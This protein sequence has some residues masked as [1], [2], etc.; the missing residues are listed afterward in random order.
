MWRWLKL[1]QVQDELSIRVCIFS[2]VILSSHVPSQL[3]SLI[4]LL[5]CLNTPVTESGTTCA[6]PQS[7]SL[8]G[9]V[10]EQSPITGYEPK[11]LIEISSEYTPT[12][13]PSRN[14]SFTT[15]TD[16]VPNVVVSDITETIEAGQLISPL[17][18]QERE[19][20][21]TSFGV[22]FFQQ[23]AAGGS[24]QQPAPSLW[25]TSNAGSCGKLQRSDES[26]SNVE[27]SLMRGKRDRDF[28]S[29][30]SSQ[31]D[32]ERILS[33]RK[34]LHEYLEKEAERG[35]QG[36]CTAQRRFPEAEVEMDR[37]SWE[38]RNSDIAPNETNQQLE[39]QRLELYQANERGWSSSR[40][41]RDK[42]NYE[43]FV[44]TVENWW[45]VDAEIRETIYRESA[46]VLYS[47]TTEQ[48]EFLEWRKRVLWSWDS[49]QLWNVHVPSEPHEIRVPE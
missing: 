21:A 34:K 29:V 23:A 38:R 17:F 10:A 37:K 32:W 3:A 18:T 19:V 25:Q 14:N 36:E 47:G 16:D 45:T 8:F 49:E 4:I 43:D 26:S 39:S 41:A 42:R 48:G 22:S 6:D 5:S 40:S 1:L 46:F 24:Q 9:R 15:D 30:S 7:G 28:G 35:L 12:Y 44:Q 2:K 13:F 11:D 31:H 33:E 27:R 20:S